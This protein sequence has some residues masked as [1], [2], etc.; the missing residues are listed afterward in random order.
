MRELTKEKLEE[1]RSW[2]RACSKKDY[3]DNKVTWTYC[4]LR[5]PNSKRKGNTYVGRIW[6]LIKNV[7]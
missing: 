6:F 7:E 1:I 2:G 4:H 5:S 3:C